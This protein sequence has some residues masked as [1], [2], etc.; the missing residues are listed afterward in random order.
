ME[1]RL[2]VKRAKH[3]DT[4]AFAE[5][6]G[7]IY[8]KLYQFALYTLK[9]PQDAEDVVSE[10]VTDAFA[11][12]GQLKREEAFSSWM[13]RIVANKCNRKMREYYESKEE[14]TEE[15]AKEDNGVWCDTREEYIDVRKTFF[16]LPKEDRLIVG[17]HVFLGYKTREIAQILQMNEN[18][19]RSRESRAIQR[20]GSRL[21]GL[22]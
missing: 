10:A 15:N 12:I 1:E 7:S 9:N 16:E 19:V 17:M 22:R 5:L 13:Y 8:K 4:N 18:T 6:Y 11:T 20:M 14:L 2:L 3:G 21:K